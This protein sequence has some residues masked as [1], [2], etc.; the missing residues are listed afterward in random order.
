M[1]DTWLSDYIIY[2]ERDGRGYA[3]RACRPLESYLK[4]RLGLPISE[5]SI[6][7]EIQHL[8]LVEGGATCDCPACQMRAPGSSGIFWA[9]NVIKDD[10]ED[11]A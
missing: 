8:K 1:N 2:S 4:K 9:V 10:V 6:L 11:A 7:A 5:Q 3:R